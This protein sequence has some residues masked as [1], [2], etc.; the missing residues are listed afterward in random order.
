V[1]AML[2]AGGALPLTF[3]A[4][5]KLVVDAVRPEETG[6]STGLNTVMRL[7]GGVV[8][9][10]L[11]ATVLENKTFAGSTVPALSAYSTAFWLSAAAGVVGVLTALAVTP[12]RGRLEVAVEAD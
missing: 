3:A 2:L 5:A 10:Q 4:M 6:V 8:G 1:L 7:I 12:R 9:S 11:A